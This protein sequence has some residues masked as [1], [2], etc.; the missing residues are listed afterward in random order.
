MISP[1][2]QADKLSFAVVVYEKGGTE[3]REVFNTAELSIGRVQGNDLMLPKGNVSKRHARLIYRD[4]RFIVTDLNS[5]NGTYVN[6]RRI[7]QATIVREGDR[8]Y[9][10]DFVLRIE[11]SPESVDVPLSTNG[12]GG[13]SPGRERLSLR[14][15]SGRPTLE[16]TAPGGGQSGPTKTAS[17]SPDA[18]VG[19]NPS[20][21]GAGPAAASPLPGGIALPSDP[22]GHI[23]V[24]DRPEPPTSSLRRQALGLLMDRMQEVLAPGA[25]D[26]DVD[27]RLTQRIDELLEGQL[28][29]LTQDG[30]LGEEV[31]RVDL[32]ADARAELLRY[33]ALTG[34]LTHEDTT[35]IVAAHFDDITALRGGQRHRVDPG[36]SSESALRRAIVRLCRFAGKP[37]GPGEISIHRQLPGGWQMWAVVD[38]AAPAGAALVLR[39]ATA[40]FAS[41]DQLAERGV[42]SHPAAE[43]LTQ[44]VRARVPILVVGARS[45]GAPLLLSALCAVDVPGPILALQSYDDF[46]PERVGVVRLASDV[47]ATSPRSIAHRGAAMTGSRLVAELSSPE[48]LVAALRIVQAGIEGTLAYLPNGAVENALI[49]LPAFVASA[50]PGTSLSVAS[51]LV[52]DAFVLVVEVVAVRGCSRLASISRIVGADADRITTEYVFRSPGDRVSQAVELEATT[53]AASFVDELKRAAPD[54]EDVPPS[55]AD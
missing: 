47:A 38:E 12:H 27:E 20:L 42:L 15:T 10:G 5:T 3:R 11:T 35:E 2:M 6:R 40:F 26:K 45:A 34:Y 33:G 17:G 16:A 8:I 36:Y 48:A 49:S 13:S 54:S 21:L 50:L 18:V 46:V 30:E 25:L 22:G 43:F 1:E 39:R 37:I 4:G 52:A 28:E 29:E 24:R 41:L 32:M 51:R 19:S 31:S 14:S 53:L 23:D 9:I 44:C 7:A 55:S